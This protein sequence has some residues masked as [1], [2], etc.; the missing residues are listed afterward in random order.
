MKK[1]IL[2]SLTIIFGVTA[3][4][5]LFLIYANTNLGFR[6]TGELLVDTSKGDN[7][8]KTEFASTTAKWAPE[9]GANYDQNLKPEITKI[10][11][12]KSLMAINKYK[13]IL[14]GKH[15]TGFEGGVMLVFTNSRGQSFDME[16]NGADYLLNGKLI[17]YLKDSMCE[18]G[19]SLAYKG[20]ICEKYTEVTDGD[21]AVYANSWGIL[22][23]LYTVK[24]PK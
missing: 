9:M 20:G 13:L 15:L 19:Y 21:W 8:D 14:E 16:V 10:T 11:A 6:Y 24:L 18:K 17:F 12:T 23:N 7:K 22:S 1:A 4:F 5:C 3:L 2:V